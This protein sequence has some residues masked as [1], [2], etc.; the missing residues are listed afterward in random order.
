MDL[1]NNI[2]TA[3][4]F[5]ISP[6]KISLGLQSNIWDKELRYF[7]GSVSPLSIL[8]YW[9]W[10]ILRSSDIFF[11]V[12]PKD[13]LLLF[14]GFDEPKGVLITMLKILGLLKDGIAKAKLSDVEKSI[15]TEYLYTYT[16]T[17]RKFLIF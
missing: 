6:I 11:W 12:I 2:K 5:N 13:I 15:Q 4:S 1:I 16:I 17:L 10:V 8:E 7:V 3:I 9:D 14:N